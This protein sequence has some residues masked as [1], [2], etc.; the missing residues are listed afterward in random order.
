[1]N[2]SIFPT[3][4]IET[5]AVRR[6]SILNFMA[7]ENGSEYSS[8]TPGEEH[9]RLLRQSSRSSKKSKM[10]IRVLFKGFNDYDDRNNEWT[11]VTGILLD[12]MHG[13][14]GPSTILAALIRLF[15]ASAGGITMAIVLM[16]KMAEKEAAVCHG[17]SSYS[18]RPY[19]YSMSGCMSK[20][21]GRTASGRLYRRRLVEHTASASTR[22]PRYCSSPDWACASGRLL[23]L[24]RQSS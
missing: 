6:S 1:M 9:T 24:P 7:D 16:V 10:S 15:L 22:F 20:G 11:T 3:E 21:P 8:S 2:C 17:I 5:D 23:S 14:E 13:L 4:K 19:R 12:E 18:P